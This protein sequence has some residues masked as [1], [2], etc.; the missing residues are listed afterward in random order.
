MA[1]S[2][3]NKMVYWIIGIPVFGFISYLGWIYYSFYKDVKEVKDSILRHTFENGPLSHPIASNDY[4]STWGAYGDFIGGT[5]NPFLTFI[6][7]GLILY[8]VYQNKKALDFNSEELALSRKAQQDS[9]ESQQLIQQTQSLQQFDSFFFSLLNQIKAYEESIDENQ[10]IDDLYALYFCKAH[11]MDF[12]ADI[13][14]DKIY[15]LNPYFL[16]IFELVKNIYE[17]I[18]NNEIID[19][20]DKI[21][22]DYVMILKVM[23]PLKIQQL[24][25]IKLYNSYEY[26]KYFIYYKF[27]ENTPLFML[28]RTNS[29]LSPLALSLVFSMKN[30][31]LEGGSKKGIEIFGNSKYI[32]DLKKSGLF[33]YFFSNPNFICLMLNS[34]EFLRAMFKFKKCVV[35][36]K[37][38]DDSLQELTI[39]P[40]NLFVNF[41]FRAST[42]K[43]FDSNFKYKDLEVFSNF[44]VI[45][46]NRYIF[47]VEYAD[48]FIFH[49]KFI[50]PDSQFEKMVRCKIEN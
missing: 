19:N 46:I 25:M 12:Q 21:S 16:S 15:E 36:F 30:L 4:V 29:Q 11:S 47:K 49:K 8:T 48:G 9:A 20:R 38:Y 27:F 10:K 18:N 28:D 22:S 31:H 32:I 39:S 17:R 26:K 41:V 6:S 42:H 13:E 23:I 34:N 7:I 40:E 44:Y 3:K 1:Q 43:I 5:L 2:Q 33:S 14:L 45:R 37:N 50:T 24:I 35:I